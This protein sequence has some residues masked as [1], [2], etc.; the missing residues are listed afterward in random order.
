MEFQLGFQTKRKRMHG[1][2]SFEGDTFSIKVLK[3]FDIA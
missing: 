2:S 1:Y 3:L